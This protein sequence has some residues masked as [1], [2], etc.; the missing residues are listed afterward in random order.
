MKCVA[1]NTQVFS[2]KKIL[3]EK[4]RK[5]LIFNWKLD[6]YVLCTLKCKNDERKRKNKWKFSKFNARR[7]DGGVKLLTNAKLYDYK[8]LTST[9]IRAQNAKFCDIIG[10]HITVFFTDLPPFF[11]NK[12]LK[13]FETFFFSTFKVTAVD[14]IS[15]LVVEYKILNKSM[16]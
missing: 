6:R 11:V 9:F 1:D 16:W 5:K 14:R 7:S 12:K 4:K 3:P 10:H 2:E 8:L 15:S 13:T